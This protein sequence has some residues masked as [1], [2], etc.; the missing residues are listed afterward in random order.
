MWIPI[1]VR[2]IKSDKGNNTWNNATKKYWFNY[3]GYSYHGVDMEKL[4]RYRIKEHYAIQK[5]RRKR[6][7]GS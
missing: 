6:R 1:F 5:K 3:R 7:K 2:R 4:H